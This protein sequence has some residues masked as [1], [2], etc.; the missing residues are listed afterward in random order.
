MK[1]SAP[2]LLIASLLLL[3]L[4][5]CGEKGNPNVD[6][7]PHVT[8]K[9]VAVFKA[10]QAED[11]DAALAQYDEGF[12]RTQSPQAWRDELKALIAERGPLREW[13]LRR[14]QADTR[15]SGK[16]FLYEYTTVHAGNKRLHHL[17]TFVWPV[18]DD[19]I[20]LLG[21]KITPWQLG[22]ED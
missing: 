12:F 10:L 3:L 7:S 8:E 11:Y 16:F 22:E 14:S 4:G 17:M 6:N 5:A 15:F 13:H 2:A 20:R 9:A 21:H 19:Q 1:H 18:N